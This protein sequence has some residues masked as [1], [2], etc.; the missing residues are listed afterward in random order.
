[1][2]FPTTRAQIRL[3]DY[4]FPAIAGTRWPPRLGRPRAGAVWRSPPMPG[5][6][7][8][9]DQRGARRQKVLAHMPIASRHGM[10]GVYSERA[11]GWL[12]LVSALISAAPDFRRKCGISLRA[13]FWSATRRRMRRIPACARLKTRWSAIA[14]T[15]RLPWSAKKRPI[16]VPAAARRQGG[17]CF[18]PLSG[19]LL[20]YARTIQLSIPLRA[21]AAPGRAP[22]LTQR[23]DRVYPGLAL[24]RTALSEVHEW[25]WSRV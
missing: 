18:D 2:Q 9:L 5:G 1:M 19:S 14:S 17:G 13:C 22:D 23:L 11:V 4:G 21:A 24:P 12:V 16:D 6:I 10:P 20:R 7:T 25:A 8:D 15:P 3:G